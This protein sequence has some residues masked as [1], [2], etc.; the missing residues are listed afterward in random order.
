MIIVQLFLAP[1][2]FDYL[3]LPLHTIIL[4]TGDKKLVGIKIYT[5]GNSAASLYILY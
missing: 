5:R 4:L 2:K 3:F 1:I